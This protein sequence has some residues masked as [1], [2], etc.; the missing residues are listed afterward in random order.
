MVIRGKRAPVAGRVCM[1]Q[2]MVDVTDIPEARVGDEATLFG[3]PEL[4]AGELAE[5]MGTIDYEVSCG[6]S[7]RV[8]RV[9]IER[10]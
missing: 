8:P 5:I 6:I 7:K 10:G 1:D 9:L 2:I 4:P 3:L